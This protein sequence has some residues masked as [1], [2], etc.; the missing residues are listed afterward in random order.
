[1]CIEGAVYINLDMD[2]FKEGIVVYHK[3]SRKRC[4]IIKINEN[5]TI[6][7]RTEKD[8]QKDYYPQELETEE[9]VTARDKNQIEEIPEENIY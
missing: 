4:V 8:E 2:K 7:V 6:K 5:Q 9:E 3:A 1:M